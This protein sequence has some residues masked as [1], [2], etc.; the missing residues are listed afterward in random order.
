MPPILTVATGIDKCTRM[1][2]VKTF[3]VHLVRRFILSAWK[4]L[5]VNEIRQSM[6]AT[7]NLS[8]VATVDLV[9]EASNVACRYRQG[10]EE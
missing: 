5:D 10:R 9:V 1:T 6:L 2:I 4:I 7:L 8:Q 3:L